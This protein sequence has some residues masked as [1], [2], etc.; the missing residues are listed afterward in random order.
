MTAFLNS[1]LKLS[2]TE[3]ELIVTQN[4]LKATQ[5]EL[6][7]TLNELTILRNTDTGQVI[8]AKVALEQFLSYAKSGNYHQMWT[9]LHSDSQKGYSGET[10][11][12]ENNIVAPKNG[13]YLIENYYVAQGQI[14][15]TWESYSNV[16]DIQVVV[17]SN[18]NMLADWVLGLIPIFGSILTSTPDTSVAVWDARLIL[19]NGQWKIFCERNA[20]TPASTTTTPTTTKPPPPTAIPGTTEISAHELSVNSSKYNGKVVWVTG[21][22]TNISSD[23]I[24]GPYLTLQDVP[25]EKA[26]FCLPSDP[27]LFS[28]LVKGQTVTIQGKVEIGIFSGEIRLRN[29]IIISK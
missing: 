13:L 16:A 17:V 26:I 15:D 25:G 27:D 21:A 19:V 20:S 23:P 4:N 8:S 10:D 1:L 18:K 14:L 28:Q 7:G 12:Q 22:I 9:M 3:Q 5:E 6:A 29:S 2:A 11:F 24:N